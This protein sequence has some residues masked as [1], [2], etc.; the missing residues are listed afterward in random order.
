VAFD[1]ALDINHAAID[2][3]RDAALDAAFALREALGE[4]FGERLSV[5][6]TLMREALERDSG[7]GNLRDTLTERGTQ[8]KGSLREVMATVLAIT[9]DATW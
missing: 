9:S 1:A 5:R 4:A 6:D 3:A 7:R 8:G 2:T